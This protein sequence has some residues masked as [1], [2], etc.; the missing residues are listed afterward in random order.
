MY[1]DWPTCETPAHLK[2]NI[3]RKEDP[4]TGFLRHFRFENGREVSVA[5]SWAEDRVSRGE[6]RFIDVE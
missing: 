6:A 5:R 2:L 1:E 4:D 3:F